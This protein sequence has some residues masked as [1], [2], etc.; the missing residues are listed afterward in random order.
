MWCSLT[1]AFGRLQCACHTL[2]NS[3]L[4]FMPRI[5]RSTQATTH[6][7]YMGFKCY[8]TCLLVIYSYHELI[9][10]SVNQI[11]SHITGG[12]IY[13]VVYE[14]S[15]IKHKIILPPK[16]KGTITY[17]AEPGNYDVNVSIQTASTLHYMLTTTST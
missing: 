7:V 14:N 10:V 2:I 15:L 3:F 8:Q 12:D 17:L 16:A 4:T 11:G 6:A 13:G 1:A 9:C 5:C